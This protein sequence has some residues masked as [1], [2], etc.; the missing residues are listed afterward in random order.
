MTA[1]VHVLQ[2]SLPHPAPLMKTQM[3]D[4]LISVM[5]SIPTIEPVGA[6]YG[7]QQSTGLLEISTH[8][9][10]YRCLSNSRLC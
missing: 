3:I 7:L 4:I 2:P 10:K 1:D 6:M 5:K 8:T 9:S